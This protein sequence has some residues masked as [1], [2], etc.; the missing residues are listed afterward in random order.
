MFTFPI[1]VGA[2]AVAHFLLG[3]LVT[4]L[5]G[6]SNHPFLLAL[7]KILIFP[8]EQFPHFIQNHAILSYVCYGLSCLCIWFLICGLVRLAYGLGGMKAAGMLS[9]VL[10]AAVI[11][12]LVALSSPPPDWNSAG[13]RYLKD[14]F[15]FLP[16]PILESAEERAMQFDIQTNADPD[17]PF[18][19]PATGRWY[20]NYRNTSSGS[21]EYD[22]V[23]VASP[24]SAIA[25]LNGFVLE[26]T[27]QRA[28]GWQAPI[29][30][31]IE[32]SDRWI[33]ETALPDRSPLPANEKNRLIRVVAKNPSGGVWIGLVALQQKM[34][35]EI[36]VGI[37][38]RAMDSVRPMSSSEES[39]SP[40]DSLATPESSEES[41]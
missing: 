7:S 9:V 19:P 13:H 10:A 38:E 32:E 21:P 3:L 2:F 18:V 30:D 1:V 37:V 27:N 40:T 25:T 26:V 23:V 15:F 28:Q 4:L 31:K 35:D 20:W 14:H 11:A 36:A 41:E 5:A 33:L 17:T 29:W 6:L 34:S 39:D 12:L 16:H 24:V 22:A 8:S